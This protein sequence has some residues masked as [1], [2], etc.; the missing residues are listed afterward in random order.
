MVAVIVL[1]HPRGPVV[2]RVSEWRQN[3]VIRGVLSESWGDL[4]TLDQSGEEAGSD[5]VL[6]VFSD[7]QCAVCKYTEEGLA[8]S[9]RRNNFRVVYRHMPLTAIHSRAEEG[10]R[11]AICAER[12]GQFYEMHTFLFQ[13]VGWQR[14][15][16]WEKIAARAGLHDPAGF[17]ACLSD[18]QTAQRLA[19]DRAFAE[20]LRV[21]GTP[22]F[23]GPKRIHVGY[24]NDA[25]IARLL[26]G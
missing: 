3:Y 8:E 11:A 7:Y 13:D 5:R 19:E 25:Q 22:T 9:M 16:D 4:V 26:E 6:V 15:D 17:V 1:L 10:A 18:E 20:R 12:Q 2:P 21:T 14:G 23:V 24:A